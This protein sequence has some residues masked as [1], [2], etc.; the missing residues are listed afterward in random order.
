MYDLLDKLDLFVETDTWHYI[1]W[2]VYLVLAIICVVVI[3][4][5][6]VKRLWLRYWAIK[7]LNKLLDL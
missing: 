3:V 1:K 4:W 5:R 7:L 6:I 2:R